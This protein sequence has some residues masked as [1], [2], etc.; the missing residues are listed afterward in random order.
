MGST[1]K[2]SFGVKRGM[3]GQE[4][5]LTNEGLQTINDKDM[6]EQLK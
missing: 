5:K 2:G 4:L 1:I 6:E 3:M